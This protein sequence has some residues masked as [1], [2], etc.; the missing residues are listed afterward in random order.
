MR[1]RH[2][3]I[4]LTVFIFAIIIVGA[5]V[6][7]K[8]HPSA[9]FI[10]EGV[11]LFAC[12][13]IYIV[14]R[15]TIRPIDLITDGIT[16]I[17]QKD[18]MSKLRKTGNPDTD[19]VIEVLNSVLRQQVDR[20]ER[21]AYEKV[22]RMIAHEVNNTVAAVI[23]PL[24]DDDPLRQRMMSM[25][26][27]VS[28]FANVVKIPAAKLQLEDLGETVDNCQLL[29]ENLCNGKNI[30]LSV[31]TTDEA[32]PVRM[33]TELFQQVLVNIVKN[34]ME[35]I[36]QSASNGEGVRQGE[37]S[38]CTYG[39]VNP[40]GEAI[41]GTGG[42]TITDNGPGISPQAEENLFTPFYTTKTD[43]QGIGLL[44][45]KDIL[46]KHNCSFSLHTCKDGLTR[47]TIIFP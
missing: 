47:F 30:H 23:T 36:M 37:I 45:I 6:L 8:E 32:I 3:F 11:L 31:N 7:Y 19:E 46:Q 44:L 42:M 25:S 17:R 13:I 34:S 43:G 4:L 35:S 5:V 21:S 16:L 29:L 24:S 12:I 41:N 18:G 9:F 27:F 20:A 14:Y 38:I 22:I 2:Y 10:A 1:I 15:K 40:Y 33:D 26:A 28:R 39:K